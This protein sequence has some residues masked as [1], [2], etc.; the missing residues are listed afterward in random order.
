MFLT[1]GDKNPVEAS[2]EFQHAADFILEREIVSGE[3]YE[4]RAFE[5]QDETAKN[6][7]LPNQLGGESPG[8][9][10]KLHSQIRGGR[11]R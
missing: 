11:P 10:A 8:N 4:R 1:N 6:L 5:A 2:H 3:A 7:N 9:R